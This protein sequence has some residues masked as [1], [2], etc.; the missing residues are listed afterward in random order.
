MPGPAFRAGETVGLHTL[1]RADLDLVARLRNEPELRRGMTLA[2][3]ESDVELE[4][5]FEDHVAEPDPNDEG[6]QFVVVPRDGDEPATDEEGTPEAVGYVSLFD[7]ERPAGN[8]EVAVTIA[9]EHQGQGYGTAAVEQLVGYGIE[10]LR[11][12][13]V[14]ARAL[15]TNDAS[16]AT[17][18]SV[19][20]TREVIQREERRVDGE[21]VDVV[22]YSLLADDWFDREDTTRGIPGSPPGA[23]AA[24]R[25]HDDPF[26]V[27][28]DADTDGDDPADAPDTDRADRGGGR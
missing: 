14:R 24:E 22:A 21:H 28:T 11:L 8:A 1:E 5:W 20:F 18:E 19:G 17:L 6:A 2:L 26:A 10:E 23:T 15:V 4:S 16:R 3:P 25:G 12:T 27:A 13:K 7:V 9:P